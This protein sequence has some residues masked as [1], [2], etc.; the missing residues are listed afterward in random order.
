MCKR[1]SLSYFIKPKRLS[2]LLQKRLTKYWAW[3]G[4]GGGWVIIW[5]STNAI[6]II[7]QFGKSTGPGFDWHGMK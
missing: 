2:I 1:F 6:E 4:G 3:G 7:E 5:G